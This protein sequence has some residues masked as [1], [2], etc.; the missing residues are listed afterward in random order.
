ML[1]VFCVY[2][3]FELLQQGRYVNPEADSDVL[4]TG[5]EW[6]FAALHLT[7]NSRYN[8]GNAWGHLEAGRIHVS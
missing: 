8:T 6:I 5:Y 3:S 7:L 1:E 4:L 2:R